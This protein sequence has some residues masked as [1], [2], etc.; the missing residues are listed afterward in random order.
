APRPC[1]AR[2]SGEASTRREESTL[3][4]RWQLETHRR[5]GVVPSGGGRKQRTRL[6]QPGLKGALGQTGAQSRSAQLGRPNAPVRSLES[7]TQSA[8]QWTRALVGLSLSA[9]RWM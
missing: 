9:S 5:L 8:F 3:G 1:G 2:W 6:R 7:T 4:A